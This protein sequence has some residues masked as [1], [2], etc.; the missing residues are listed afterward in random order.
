MPG[1]EK[2]QKIIYLIDFGL[3][4]RYKD[5]KTGNHIPYKSGKSLTG[6][7]RY[8][9][10]N[11]HLGAEQSRRDDLEALG[12]VLIYFLKGC[13][14]WQGLKAKDKEQKYE[15]IKNKKKETSIETLCESLPSEFV[16]YLNTCRKLRFDENPDYNYLKSLFKGLLA[17]S[18]YENDGMYDWL[19]Q[20]PISGY[21][22]LT[23]CI[24]LLNLRC[25]KRRNSRIT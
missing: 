1:I 10:L 3:S 13:L 6:T 18:G 11:T 15:A 21:K 2:N 4:K 16:T 19:A 20:K 23:E 5:P 24:D 25:K 17:R 8:A 22:P 12:F 14:P 7:A 9:S